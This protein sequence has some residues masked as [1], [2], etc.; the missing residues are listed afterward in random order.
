MQLPPQVAVTAQAKMSVLGVTRAAVAAAS[1]ATS[2]ALRVETKDGVLVL[3]GGAWYLEGTGG[4]LL[5]ATGM[6]GSVNGQR[7]PIQ[8][9][10]AG[11]ELGQGPVTVQ[12]VHSKLGYIAG[13]QSMCRTQ[14]HPLAAS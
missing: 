5:A 6:L 7:A 1:G 8:G 12:A 4:M 11:G 2:T 13:G 9:P 14:E 10:A 3:Q